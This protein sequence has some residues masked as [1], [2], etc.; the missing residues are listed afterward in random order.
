MSCIFVHFPDFFQYVQN[1][2]TFLWL[3]DWKMLS[4]FARFSGRYG[5]HENITSVKVDWRVTA[6]HSS[7]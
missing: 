2:V 3:A 1:S 4:H 5:N 7:F 6:E